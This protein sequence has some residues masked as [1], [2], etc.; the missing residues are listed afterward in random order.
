MSMS[1]ILSESLGKT[2]LWAE[3][4]T[5]CSTLEQRGELFLSNQSNNACPIEFEDLAHFETP[6]LQGPS[7]STAN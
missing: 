5:L 2:R 6:Q 3:P 7:D 4:E 1:G